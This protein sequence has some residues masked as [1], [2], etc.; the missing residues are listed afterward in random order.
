MPQ[1]VQPVLPLLPLVLVAGQRTREALPSQWQTVQQLLSWQTVSPQALQ[2]ALL[3]SA[4]PSRVLQ[5]QTLLA[6]TTTTRSS[7][8]LTQP[9]RSRRRGSHSSQMMRYPWPLLQLLQAQAD[10]WRPPPRYC[11]RC[12]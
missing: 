10:A 6:K 11:Y 5:L 8:Q 2:A 12:C 7:R 1:T 3:P 4:V 9:M